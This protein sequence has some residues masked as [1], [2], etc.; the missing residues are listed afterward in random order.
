[1]M[2]MSSSNPTITPPR[3]ALTMVEA[4]AS[5]GMSARSFQYLVDDKSNGLASLIVKLGAKRVIPLPALQN[6]LLEKQGQ[7]ISIDTTPK[8]K[9]SAQRHLTT[10]ES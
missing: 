5:I 4:A 7:A 2:S 3:L 8:G 1:M 6:W 9:Q 10:K